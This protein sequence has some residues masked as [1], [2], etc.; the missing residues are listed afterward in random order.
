MVCY[1]LTGVTCFAHH[2]LFADLNVELGTVSDR[3]LNCMHVSVVLVWYVLP[4]ST[5]NFP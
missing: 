5:L 3:L 4:L 1:S 2:F